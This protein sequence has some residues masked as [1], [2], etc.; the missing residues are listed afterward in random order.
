LAKLVIRRAVEAILVLLL[1][2]FAS[3]MLTNLLPGNEAAEICSVGATAQ[4]IARET[5]FLGLN[6]SIWDQYW[7]WLGH[8]LSGNFGSSFLS[9]GGEA[10]STIIKQ[11]YA[12][13]LELIIYS[14]V[15]ALIIAI[16]LAMWAAL[17]PNR[18]F[19]RLSS[20]V[21]FGALSLPPFIIGPLLALFFTAELHI[22][23]GPDTSVPSFG[24][25]VFTNLRV[26]FL[27]SFTLTIASISV[28]Q[29]LLRA[30]MIATLEEDFVVMARAK[31]LSTS[32]ILFRHAFRPSTFS[33]VTVGGIQIGGLITGAIISE[34]VFGLHGLGTALVAAV[35]TKDYPTVQIVTVIV[36]VAYVVINILIDFLYAFIDPR[37]RRARASS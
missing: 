26:M 6:H 13:T 29:R 5:A 35:A 1:V 33:L 28:Y 16:P 20:T 21:S 24:A 7:I 4:C 37:I 34:T 11:S 3:F 32:R 12:V 31:G 17:R 30:D 19:D 23:P 8:F 2:T 9:G 27:P 25:D 22:F 14:Q 36:A 15:M 18:I 10:I